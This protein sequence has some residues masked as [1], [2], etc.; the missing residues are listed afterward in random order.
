MDG[1][2][3]LNLTAAEIA[4]V[5]SDPVLAAKYPPILTIEE[6][7]DLLRE[8]IETLRSWRSRGR[9]SSCSASGGSTGSSPASTAS[10]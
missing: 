2:K 8:E 9:L 7:A 1:K 10:R 5:F 4:K 3:G 6:A